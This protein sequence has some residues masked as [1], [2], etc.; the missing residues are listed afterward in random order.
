[1]AA[2]IFLHFEGPELKGETRDSELK[3]Q[4]ECLSWSFGESQPS[5]ARSTSGGPSGRVEL[6]ELNITKLTDKA[7]PQL[8]LNCAIG[9]IFKTATLSIRKATGEKTSQK[10]YIIVKLGNVLISGY[11]ISGA[12]GAGAPTENV[13]L[14]YTKIT[15]DYKLQDATKGTLTSAGEVTYDSETGKSG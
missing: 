7:T 11:Q 4:I 3:D 1:M 15:Y 8:F 9:Q 13:S 10:P 12:N 5:S 2:D 14:S 6:G